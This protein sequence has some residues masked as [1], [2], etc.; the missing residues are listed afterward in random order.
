ME[1]V[2]K[3][4]M[5]IP[6]LQRSSCWSSASVSSSPPLLLLPSL[7]GLQYSSSSSS[8]SCRCWTKNLPTVNCYST[9]IA[10][11]HLSSPVIGCR[12]YYK[13][14]NSSTAVAMAV[15]S[16][17]SSS[18]STP[19]QQAVE[20]EE[21][22]TVASNVSFFLKLWCFEAP[23]APPI[24]M[25]LWYRNFANLL[26]WVGG[27]VFCGISLLH[28]EPLSLCKSL[29]ASFQSWTS[30]LIS[31]FLTNL[32][33]SSKLGFCTKFVFIWSAWI[34]AQNVRRGGVGAG[35]DSGRSRTSRLSS[36]N[37]PSAQRLLC[38]PV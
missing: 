35:G 37:L 5:T 8:S 17:S 23:D 26:L 18:S 15:A 6:V 16:P 11:K 24:R 9:K 25:P 36:C 31:R 30:S 34:N 32:D 10:K 27:W 3:P 19:A 28:Y 14:Q 1:I 7:S 13:R 29:F 33:R 20:E 4:V 22:E 38:E 2:V 12:Y 21:K